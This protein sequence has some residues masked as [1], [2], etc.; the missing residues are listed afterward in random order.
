M[1]VLCAGSDSWGKIA[2]LP[3]QVGRPGRLAAC[4]TA[5]QASSLRYGKTTG[6]GIVIDTVV[7]IPIPGR[8]IPPEDGRASSPDEAAYLASKE[9]F[10]G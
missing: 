1:A 10:L 9:A 2:D 5:R 7:E 8:W 6:L 4:P 3:G